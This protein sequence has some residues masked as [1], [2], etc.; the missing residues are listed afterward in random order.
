[1]QPAGY[2]VS[3]RVAHGASWVWEPWTKWCWRDKG[4]NRLQ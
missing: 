2:L 3:P 4:T 1:M